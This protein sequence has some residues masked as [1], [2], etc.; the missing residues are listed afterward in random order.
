MM[1]FKVKIGKDE[2]ELE[3]E[4]VECRNCRIDNAVAMLFPIL[5]REQKICLCSEKPTGICVTEIAMKKEQYAK[6]WKFM[7][8]INYC[9]KFTCICEKESKNIEECNIA[10]CVHSHSGCSSGSSDT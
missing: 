3:G 4:P 1:K 10:S 9:L 6:E 8:H 5:G 2:I 7:F